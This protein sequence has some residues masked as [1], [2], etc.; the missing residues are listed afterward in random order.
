MTRRLAALHALVLLA[1]V[2]GCGGGN[3][4]P[5]APSTPTPTPAAPTTFTLSGAVTVGNTSGAGIPGA[6]VAIFD[7]ADAGKSTTTDGNGRYSI[8]GLRTGGFTTNVTAP[9]YVSGSRGISLTTNTTANFGLLPT[10]IWTQG[11]TGD[12]VF[13]MP[14]YITRV[15]IQANYGGFCQNFAVYIAGRLIVN[16]ILGT[17]S[18]ALGRNFDGTY[19]TSGGTVETK[20]SSGVNWSFLEQR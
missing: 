17:C 19:T 12:R 11:G 13:D 4:S 20:I 5:T 6:T 16:E 2:A 8:A 7:G 18:S 15:R 14:T 1:F 10:T 3:S 9:G